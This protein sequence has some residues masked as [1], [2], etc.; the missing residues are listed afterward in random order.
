MQA[1]AEIAEVTSLVDDAF[2]PSAWLT[3][4]SDMIGP[5]SSSLLT[6]QGD[7]AAAMRDSWDWWRPDSASGAPLLGWLLFVGPLLLLLLAALG[8]L[9]MASSAHTDSCRSRTGVSA[10]ARVRVRVP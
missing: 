9:C 8:V 4:V 2:G 5:L 10:R 3:S 7:L 1:L 6:T